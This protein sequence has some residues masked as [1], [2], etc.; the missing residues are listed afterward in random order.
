VTDFSDSLNEAFSGCTSL[1]DIELSRHTLIGEDA[2][3]DV[4][5]RLWYRD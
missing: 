5:G 1:A 4:P 2:F 3:E